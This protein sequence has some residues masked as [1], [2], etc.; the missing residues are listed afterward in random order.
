MHGGTMF[1]KFAT[2]LLLFVA[3]LGLAGHAYAAVSIRVEQPKTPTN[4]SSF[5]INFVALDTNG[6]PITVTCYKKGPSDGALVQFGSP[7]VLSAGGN[8]GNCNVDGS[9]LNENGGYLFEVRTDSGALDNATVTYN[10]SGPGDVRDYSKNHTNSCEYTIHFKSAADSGKT[11]KVEVYRSES[12]PFNADS[13]SRIQTVPVGSDETRDVTNTP[14]DCSKTYYYA[15]R[16]FDSSG[17]GSALIGD[18]VNTTTVINPT[19]SPA[20]GAAIPVSSTN[21]NVLGVS[22]GTTGAS[23]ATGQSG[24]V[25]GLST[26]S[27]ETVNLPAEAKPYYLA[28]PKRTMLIVGGILIFGAIL[29]A[30]WSRRKNQTNV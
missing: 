21:G 25:E 8:T 20:Q 9:I 30:F 24:Q 18:D 27:A 23:G 11:V 28:H 5:P 19:G 15:V 10:T 6:G 12:V 13:G 4:Q 17:N 26:P 2:T 1:K 7:I 14:P 16:A 29:Y 3:S 22:N